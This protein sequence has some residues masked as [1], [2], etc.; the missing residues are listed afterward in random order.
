MNGRLNNYINSCLV[1]LFL[2]LMLYLVRPILFPFITA[3]II[4]YLLNPCINKLVNYKLPRIYSVLFVLF[5]FLALFMIFLVILIPI[6]YMQLVSLSSFLINK[7]PFIKGKIMPVLLKIYEQLDIANL[8]DTTNM[9]NNLPGS[10]FENHAIIALLNSL[11][12]ITSNLITGAFSS[13]IDFINALTLIFITPILLFYV[14]CNWPLIVKNINSLIPISYNETVKD[15]FTQIDSL[16]SAYLR[17]Q[18]SVCLI[19]A[20]FY[21]I[22]LKVVGLNYWLLIGL[23]SGIMT[24][25]PY[26]GSIVCM[27]VVLFIAISQFD[28]LLMYCTVLSSFILGQVIEGTIITPLLIGKKV[29]LHPVWIIIGMIICASQIGFL[30][31]LFSIPITAISS[32]FIK[33]IIKKYTSS[34]F[35]NK[36]N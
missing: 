22:A 11:L 21:S 25:I 35:Y 5:A 16:I 1:V 31:I 2:I 36:C 19:M 15:Y 20:M 23:I 3:T 24:F 17:G 12:K 4:A 6:A 9:L 32:V 34:G 29:K 10:L 13:S 14:L 28:S 33:A 18:I 30:G 26:I 27:I 7:I 8:S